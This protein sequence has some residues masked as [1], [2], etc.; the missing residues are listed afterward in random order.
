MKTNISFIVRIVAWSLPAIV[1]ACS[2]L[3][4]QTFSGDFDRVLTPGSASVQIG[5]YAGATYS[6]H[7]GRF[8]TTERNIVCCEF[9]NGEGFGPAAGVK[10]SL[11][12][13]EAFFV[14]PSLGYESRGGTFDAAPQ[15]LPIFG[16]NNSVENITMRSSMDVSLGTLNIEALAGYRIGATGMYLTAGPAASVVLSQHY[17]KSE[18]IDNPANVTYLGGGTEKVLYDGDLDL[19]KSTLFSVRAGAG[20]S[21]EIADGVSLAPQVLYSLPLGKASRSDEW[22]VAG[23]HGTVAVLFDL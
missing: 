1:A 2:A 4:A 12:L 11:S 17:R 5:P 13:S 15:Q 8:V 23:M 7:N 18:R 22:T 6:L 20:A 9:N 10:M 14:A 16:L 19:V 21:F 3:S